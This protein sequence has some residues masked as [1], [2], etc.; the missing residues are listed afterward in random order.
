MEAISGC[1]SYR[2][3]TRA[4]TALTVMTLR[5]DSVSMASGLVTQGS[6]A[7]ARVDRLAD[8]LR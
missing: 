1:A 8:P 6:L 2:F 7:G 3:A 5:G 4:A